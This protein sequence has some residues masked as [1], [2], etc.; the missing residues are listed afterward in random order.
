ME[1]MY[2]SNNKVLTLLP[3]LISTIG[4]TPEQTF[5]TITP[6]GNKF[7][8]YNFAYHNSNP[9][10]LPLD[11]IIDALVYGNISL[12]SNAIK[13]D[14]FTVVSEK[15]SKLT[16]TGSGTVFLWYRYHRLNPASFQIIMKYA[17]QQ[18][19]YILIDALLHTLSIRE[20]I[21]FVLQT[22]QIQELFKK[23]L[24]WQF[25]KLGFTD[26]LSYINGG[27]YDIR[28]LALFLTVATYAFPFLFNYTT[29]PKIAGDPLTVYIE[30][31]SYLN[32][33]GQTITS[34]IDYLS[35]VVYYQSS[36]I[37]ELNSEIMYL[38]TQSILH[39]Q[40]M[41]ALSSDLDL[42]SSEF[43]SC[44]SEVNNMI[45]VLN[46]IINKLKEEIEEIKSEINEIINN[47][48]QSSSSSSTPSG[49]SPPSSYTS[50]NSSSTP[51]S[52]S[53]PSSGS[54]SST[55]SNS[56]STSNSSESSSS[57]SESSS[58][59][60]CQKLVDSLSICRFC[61]ENNQNCDEC[62]NTLK[63][64][65]E[66]GCQFNCS[67][68]YC[69]IS[70]VCASC[71]ASN[72][73]MS[74]EACHELIDLCTNTGNTSGLPCTSKFECVRLLAEQ[75]CPTGNHIPTPSEPLP[76]PTV[77]EVGNSSEPSKIVLPIHEPTAS[78]PQPPI[79][80]PQPS[81]PSPI[82]SEPR[83]SEPS[84][85]PSE[86]STPITHRLIIPASTSSSEKETAK[87]LY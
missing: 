63:L 72:A 16:I 77:S 47:K 52:S 78:E 10:I 56:S 50:P 4:D 74:C 39:Q 8:V 33:F 42:I 32:E 70:Y 37:A 25:N 41:G 45:N 29:I 35:E 79:S 13:T 12:S 55:S 84:P 59:E 81:E 87:K 49:S 5:V 54:S 23:G 17:I 83:L 64:I 3:D 30:Y 48:E 86:P 46:C 24:D 14:V 43:D 18:N 76:R 26:F 22:Q 60:E 62:L 67:S 71:I 27:K 1:S 57:S 68:V 15:T 85:T 75:A 7:N 69:P 38:E 73:Q 65:K 58:S 44:C 80:I 28:R 36:E 20:A 40:E 9:L 51:S 31:L 66:K 34:E 82:P 2:T 19:D 61:I 21:S 53:P 6:Y 11:V